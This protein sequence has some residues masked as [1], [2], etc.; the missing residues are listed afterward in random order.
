M[1]LAADDG[2]GGRAELGQRRGNV[3]CAEE[4]QRGGARA[5]AGLETTRGCC[6]KQEMVPV[7]L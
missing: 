1:L 4:G 6:Q 3:E 7:G 2:R 5:A